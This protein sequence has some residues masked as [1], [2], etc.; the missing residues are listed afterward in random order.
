MIGPAEQVPVG[1]DAPLCAQEIGVAAGPRRQTLHVVR[2]HGVEQTGAVLTDGLDF[3]A[4][5]QVE[6][7]RSI[8]QCFV[9]GGNSNLGHTQSDDIHRKRAE[10]KMTISPEIAMLVSQRR[11]LASPAFGTVYKTVTAKMCRTNRNLIPITM[12]YCGG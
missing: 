8:A 3:P 4:G 2:G 11:R 1:E 6:P 7:G 10:M 5:R 9:S 12:W